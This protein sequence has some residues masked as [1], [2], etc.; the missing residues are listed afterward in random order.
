MRNKFELLRQEIINHE[1][2]TEM[3]L[4][5]YEPL[6]SA[7]EKSKIVVIGQA[8]GSRAQTTGVP[9]NDK[10]GETLREWLGVSKEVFYNPDQIS[11]IPMDFYYPGKGTH[12]DLP[13]RKDFAA[14][15]HS[16]LF[17]LM[18]NI[19]LK[20]LVG[21]YA[22]NYYLGKSKKVNLTETVKAHKQYLPEFFPIVHPSPLNF[23]WQSKNP[24]FKDQVVEELRKQV[25]NILENS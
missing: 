12:G 8:P 22:Q 9:W 11:L 17:D 4:K 14:K 23:R 20:V 21:S 18:P 19:R 10:S 7:S 1:E 15:W 16:Q 5:G 6:Y 24:W 13:P 3:L 2:N 25:K